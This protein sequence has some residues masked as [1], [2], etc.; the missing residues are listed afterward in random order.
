M[1]ER[2]LSNTELKFDYI[3]QTKRSADAKRDKHKVLSV[4]I[5][6][7]SIVESTLRSTLVALFNNAKNGNNDVLREALKDRE[8]NYNTI[9]DI[10]QNLHTPPANLTNA[11]IDFRRYLIKLTRKFLKQEA[12]I[13]IDVKSILSTEALMIYSLFSLLRLID[14]DLIEKHTT[15]ASRKKYIRSMAQYR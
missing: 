12:N 2:K 14:T 5:N 13:N 11:I 9:N 15:E 4:T 1:L 10:I 6:D 8:L 7:K 3:S